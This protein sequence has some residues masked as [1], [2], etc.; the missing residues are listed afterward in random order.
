MSSYSS[1]C[2]PLLSPLPPCPP[3][4]SSLFSSHIHSAPAIIQPGDNTTTVITD[5]GIAYFQTSC[6]AFS[7]NVLVELIDE[8]GSTFLFASGTQTNPGPLTFSTIANITTGISRR[9]V[10]LTLR[11]TSS[12]HN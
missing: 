6:P 8:S 4:L 3:P 7:D 12:V 1:H 2:L 11:G 10:T 5:G 9:T